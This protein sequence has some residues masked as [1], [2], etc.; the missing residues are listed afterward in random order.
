MKHEVT[1]QT[2]QMNR[3]ATRTTLWRLTPAARKAV[4]VLHVVAGIGWMGVDI[5]LLVLLITARTTND[6]ALV[7]SGF[8]AIR[9]IVPIAVP[10]LSLG[11]LVTGLILGLGTR[12]GLVRYWWVL[13]KLLLSLIMTVLVF[14]SLVP[15]VSDIAVLSVTT[16]SADAVR[17]S[18]GTLPTMLLFPPIVSFLMLGVAAILSIF[19]P[20]QLTPWRRESS[21]ELIKDV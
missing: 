7:V 12:W 21:P 14:V 4:L 18:L 5:A 20:W 8:N 2:K 11:I 9:M 10:P 16:L 13:V 1:T 3:I 15:A 6:A 19:K 17:A